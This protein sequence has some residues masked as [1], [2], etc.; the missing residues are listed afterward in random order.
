MQ[1][2]SSVGNATGFAFGGWHTNPTHG[3][4]IANV[5]RNVNAKNGRK[6]IVYCAWPMPPSESWRL[7]GLG[8]AHAPHAP[9][10]I[11]LAVVSFENMRHMILL[12]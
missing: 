8:I 5:N 6:K 12:G 4:Y 10:K 2:D 9:I 3:Q 11:S 7:C 1:L